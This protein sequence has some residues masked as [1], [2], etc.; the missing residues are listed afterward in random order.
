M[1]FNHEK[2]NKWEEETHIPKPIFDMCNF[3]ADK[4]GCGPIFE[5]T[6][7]IYNRGGYVVGYGKGFSLTHCTSSLLDGPSVDYSD[8][9]KKWLKGLDF[10]IENSYGDNGMDSSTNYH[11]TYWTHEFIYNP[12][13]VYDDEFTIWEESDYND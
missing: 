7:K 3:I 1:R 13:I 12:S 5:E 4:I 11:D 8:T 10:S 6:I 2:F 9:I